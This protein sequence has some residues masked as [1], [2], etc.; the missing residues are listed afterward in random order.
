MLVWTTA[1]IDLTT[2]TCRPHYRCERTV[3]FMS[4]TKIITISANAT[5]TRNF[6][7]NT[8]SPSPVMSLHLTR[9]TE[10]LSALPAFFRV[11]PRF[12]ALSD[13]H[14]KRFCSRQFLW[15]KNLAC[16]ADPI[17][18]LERNRGFEP[19]RPAWKA[20]MLAVEHQFRRC[21]TLIYHLGLRQYI[22]SY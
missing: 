11:S 20:G 1:S 6:N 21:S 5:Q 18:A 17:R 4:W 3:I 13:F 14:R 12:C 8:S 7:H 22:H 9:L 15:V 10:E 16:A 19:P 2:P